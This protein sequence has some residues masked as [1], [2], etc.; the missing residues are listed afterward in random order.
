MT[1]TV[2]LNTV[3]LLAE[4]L[5]QPVH[6]VEYVIRTRSHINHVAVAGRT[7][8]FDDGAARQLRHEFNA[9]DAR[10]S[11]GIPDEA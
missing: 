11:G 1:T 6:R 7:R 10:K 9:I 3:G 2:R 4:K 8:L 5:G